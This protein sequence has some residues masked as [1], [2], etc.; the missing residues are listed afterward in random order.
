M[1]NLL[2]VTVSDCFTDLAEQVT[3]DLLGEPLPPPDIA[4]QVSAPA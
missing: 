3:G 1:R 2:V 4:E